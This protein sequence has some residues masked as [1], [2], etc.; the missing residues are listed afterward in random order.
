MVLA[1]GS[2]TLAQ[3][4]FDASGEDF[5]VVAV[6]T[7]RPTAPVVERAL[8]VGIAVHVLPVSDYPSRADW[9]AALARLLTDLTPDL[10]VSAGFMRIIGSAVLARFEG[11]IINTH[12]SLLPQFP[13]AHAVADA[14][15]A[16]V[17]T[18]GATVH[19]VDHGMDT[20]AV[21]AQATVDITEDDTE[22]TLHER[23]KQVER[24]LIVDVIGDLV[25]TRR[26]EP[27]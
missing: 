3:A 11:D 27:R 8:Q 4:I 18:T 26:Q 17:T 14:L 20:G 24:R 23:I 21:L 6:V 15:A 2:G 12:P 19:L 10:I 22:E 7:D 5:V 1:S 16:G 9:D 25:R 13:G